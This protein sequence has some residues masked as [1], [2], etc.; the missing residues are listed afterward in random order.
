MSEYIYGKNA[1]KATLENPKRVIGL[2]CEDNQQ[3]MIRLAVKMNVA[4]QIVSRKKL[5]QLVTGLHQGVVC[6]VESYPLTDLE[7]LIRQARANY[8][9][10]IMLDGIEDP[11]NLGA[12]LRT[13]DAVGADGIILPKNRSVGLT[14]AVAKV[15]TGAIEYVKVAEVTNLVATL[16][17]LKAKGYW[18]VGLELAPKAVD[19]HSMKYDMPMVLV[20]GSEGKGIS[21]LVLE[22]CD[23]IVKLPMVGHVNSLNASVSCGIMLYEMIKY[24]KE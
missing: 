18:V 24:R 19:F 11:H 21:R 7:E 17:V 1:V 13:A 4:Y 8:P 12:I 2:Y 14:G 23:F 3:E 6:E 20:V 15:S 10:L 22:H 16:K 5:D 9:I